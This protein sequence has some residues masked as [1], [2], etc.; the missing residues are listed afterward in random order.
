MVK[1]NISKIKAQIAHACAKSGRNANEVSIVAVTKARAPEDIEEVLRAGLTDVGEN[2][3]Q[4]AVAK[5]AKVKGAR[6]HFIG[7][8]Q[9]N[10]VKEAVRIFDLIQSVDSIHLAE[11]IDRQAQKIGKVQDILVEIKTSAEATKFGFLPLDL[12]RAIEEITK[13]KNI[14]LAGL[15]TIA[16]LT[17]AAEGSRPYFRILR[18]LRDKINKDWILSMGMSD[19]FKIAIEEGSTMV[20]IGRAIFEG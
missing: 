17:G 6:W 1:D 20:R 9:T 7:H 14:N 4:E 3:I 16:A 12:P 10:K 5:Q 2:K 13:L 8:L 11:E 15:M 19:D 18:E